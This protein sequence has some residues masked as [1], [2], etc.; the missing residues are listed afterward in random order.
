MTEKKEEMFHVTSESMTPQSP[1]LQGHWGGGQIGQDNSPALSV[2]LSVDEKL[3][4]RRPA[5]R[6]H[7]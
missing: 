1:E 5:P 4:Q 7:K 2:Y 3:H 6:S